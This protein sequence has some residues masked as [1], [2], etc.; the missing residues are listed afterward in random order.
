[1]LRTKNRRAPARLSKLMQKMMRSAFQVESLEQRILLSADPIASALQMITPH[2]ADHVQYQNIDASQAL[3]STGAATA[4][5]AET[6]APAGNVI[7]VGESINF[8]VDEQTFN[9]ALEQTRAAFMDSEIVLS[10]QPY[11]QFMDSVLSTNVIGTRSQ[12]M[13]LGGSANF[14]DSLTAVDAL[15]LTATSTT[16]I[17]LGASA[18]GSGQG[19]VGRIDVAGMAT[20]NGS[21]NITLAD[22]FIPQEGEVFTLLT[23]GSVSGKFTDASGLVDAEHGIYY[24]I[25]QDAN[26]LKLVAHTLDTTTAFLVS[27]LHGDGGV[28]AATDRR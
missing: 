16:A 6:D 27:A 9:K 18:D 24:E 2:G 17:E 28:A 15:T 7:A 11:A 25:Q 1:M 23:F 22:G 5:Q 10:D 8:E 26:S 12:E 13:A 3:G 14:S 20:L 19:V 21:L 4:T